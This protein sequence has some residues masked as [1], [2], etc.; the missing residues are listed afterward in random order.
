MGAAVCAVAPASARAYQGQFE[1]LSRDEALGTVARE[2]LRIRAAHGLGQRL[3]SAGTDARLCRRMRG[4]M[5]KDWD[6]IVRVDP[7]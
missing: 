3:V 4:D 1:R 5:L 2:M 6:G 7:A